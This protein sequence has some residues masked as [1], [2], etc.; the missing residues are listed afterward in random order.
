M[1][2]NLISFENGRRPQFF[3]KWKTTSIL[4]WKWKTT[5]ILFWKWKTISI[6]LKMEDDLKNFINGR[7]CHFFCKW[8]TT[9]I[10]L[11][12]EDDLIFL[13]KRTT[14]FF[15]FNARRNWLTNLTWPE[16]GTAQP[17]LVFSSLSLLDFLLWADL[18]SDW[19]M[20]QRQAYSF[21][22]WN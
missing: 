7:R 11:E 22:A 5:L 9:S 3:G 8:K 13:W 6:F 20:T 10:S 14:F 12:K 1:E 4:F 18:V 21:A 16:L 2:D 17:Q 19:L 15:C